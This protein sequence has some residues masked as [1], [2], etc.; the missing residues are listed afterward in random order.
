MPIPM[1][2]R[3]WDAVGAIA[4]VSSFTVDEIR[5]VS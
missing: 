2:D 3:Y 4:D 1:L 5:E